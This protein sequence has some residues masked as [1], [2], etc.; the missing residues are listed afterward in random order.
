MPDSETD[1]RI[2]G[3]SKDRDKSGLKVRDA[4]NSHASILGTLPAFVVNH[5]DHDFGIEYQI[6][7]RHTQPFAGR[8]SAF[9]NEPGI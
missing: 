9:R 3:W 5:D 4:A 6:I 1:C 8:S 2:E 7:G